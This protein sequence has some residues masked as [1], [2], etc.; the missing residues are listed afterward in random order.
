MNHEWEPIAPYVG[1]SGVRESFEC[2]HCFQ[3]RLGDV[4]SE[5]Q[6]SCWGGAYLVWNGIEECDEASLERA[7]DAKERCSVGAVI[8]SLGAFLGERKPGFLFTGGI[9]Y[10]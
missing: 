8:E 9:P 4:F 5:P 3:V 7:R 10:R 6:Q 2:K 1:S